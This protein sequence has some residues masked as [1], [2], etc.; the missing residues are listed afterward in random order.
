MKKALDNLKKT[1]PPKARIAIL[2]AFGGISIVSYLLYSVLSSGEDDIPAQNGLT[3]VE[4]VIE[5][6]TRIEKSNLI[7]KD[8]SI[9]K[10]IADLE[11]QNIESMKSSDEDVSYFGGI[12]LSKGK[13]IQ[14]EDGAEMVNSDVVDLSAMFNETEEE[15]EERESNEKERIE[16]VGSRLDIPQPKPQGVLF[17]RDEYLSEVRASIVNNDNS[18]DSA[19]WE[20]LRANQSLVINDYSSSNENE[21][22]GLTRERTR[23]WGKLRKLVF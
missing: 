20:G 7:A 21:S 3:K 17:N 11:K 10:Q 6:E 16:D 1:V 8:N 22:G 18:N 9:N 2:A 15:K 14:E 4:T 23:F 19:R 5:K 13:S 12:D